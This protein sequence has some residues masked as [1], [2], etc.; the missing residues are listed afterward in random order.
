MAEIA[1]RASVKLKLNSSKIVQKV[2]A[3]LFYSEIKFVHGE[4]TNY[5]YRTEN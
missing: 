4:K 2:A 3:K 1:E 5:S